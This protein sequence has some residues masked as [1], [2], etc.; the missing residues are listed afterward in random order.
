MIKRFNT[1]VNKAGQ[2]NNQ[3]NVQPITLPPAPKV[4]VTKAVDLIQRSGIPNVGNSCFFASAL[5][6]LAHF[7]VYRNAFD[8]QLSP[9][10][11]QE[12]ETDLEFI[13]KQAIQ[14]EI[15]LLLNKIIAGD[16]TLDIQPTRKKNC[17]IAR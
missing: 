5:Q 8:P 11:K 17:F 6:V 1:A 4:G 9:L 15:H 7:P 12:D 3:I 14:E 2:I 13:E 10:V 16:K